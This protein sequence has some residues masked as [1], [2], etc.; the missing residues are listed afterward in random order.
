MGG[1][2]TDYM[3]VAHPYTALCPTLDSGVLSVLA[4]TTRPLTGREIARLLGRRSHAGVRDALNRLAEQGVVDRQEAGR[5]LLF[6]LNR[7]HLAAPAVDV[8]AGMRGELLNR[9]RNAIGS[10]EVA[11]AHVSMFGSAARGEGG[12]DSDIDLFV[13]RP[14]GVDE[15]DP[16]WRG[17]LDLLSRQVQRWTGNRAG[18]AET[19]ESEIARLRKDEPPIVEALRSDAITLAGPEVAALLGAA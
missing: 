7:E 1:I 14:E 5:A 16:Q 2:V 19:S 15:E 9:L 10:W 12:T 17:Q 8:L 18:I 4:G 6:T 13:V 11:P 3:D